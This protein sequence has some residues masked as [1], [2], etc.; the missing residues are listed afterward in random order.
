MRNQHIW[1]EVIMSLRSHSY[2]SNTTLPLWSNSIQLQ[3]EEYV[4]VM[5]HIKILWLNSYKEEKV[6]NFREDLN[7]TFSGWDAR[8]CLETSDYIKWLGTVYKIRWL[9]EWHSERW[10]WEERKGKYKWTWCK[11]NPKWEL[12]MEAMG[13]YD[14]R[15]VFT[16]Y[17]RCKGLEKN[18]I[19]YLQS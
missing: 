12:E 18:G 13:K 1:K 7:F 16:T 10:R 17:T 15:R 2:Y 8:I 5:E 14:T 6:R 9:V 4:I 19:Y 11:K 3:P